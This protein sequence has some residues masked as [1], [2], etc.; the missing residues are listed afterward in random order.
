MRRTNRHSLVAPALAVLVAVAAWAPSAVAQG[1]DAA[2]LERLQRIIEQQQGQIEAQAKLLRSLQGQV[3]ALVRSAAQATETANQASRAASQAAIQA[4]AVAQ[5]A[6]E[7]ASQAQ[8][9]KKMVRSG[10][11]A[12][13]LTLSGQVNRG[14]LIA[15]DGNNTHIFH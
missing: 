2:Q 6:S 1:V 15:D 5:Q 10:K 7:Q 14:V 8:E 12:I 4:A 9:P 3:D 11:S 13:K